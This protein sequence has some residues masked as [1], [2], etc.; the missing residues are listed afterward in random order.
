MYRKFVDTVEERDTDNVP[1]LIP[2]MDARSC[3]GLV[4]ALRIQSGKENP[5][6]GVTLH[7]VQSF[8]VLTYQYERSDI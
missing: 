8:D 5:D 1:R 7:N 6:F 2:C 3:L 4:W